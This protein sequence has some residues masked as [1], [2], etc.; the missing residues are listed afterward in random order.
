LDALAPAGGVE[1]SAAIRE[2][3]HAAAEKLRRGQLVAAS[4]AIRNDPVEQA[5]LRKIMAEMDQISAW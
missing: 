1:R 5:E 3:I 4:D 2:A